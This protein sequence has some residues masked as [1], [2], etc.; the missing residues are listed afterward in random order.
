VNGPVTITRRPGTAEAIRFNGT[1]AALIANWAGPKRTVDEHPAGATY[2]GGQLVIHTSQ[3]DMTPLLG[4][5]V[6]QFDGEIYPVRTKA[7]NA[8]WEVIDQ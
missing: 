4:E 5:W 6:I 8:G 3:G 1:N 2:D 7:F